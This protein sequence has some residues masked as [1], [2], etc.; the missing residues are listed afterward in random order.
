MMN[1]GRAI[2]I[3]PAVLRMANI[4][5]QGLQTL[6]II[7]VKEESSKKRTEREKLEEELYEKEASYTM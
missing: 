6:L 4:Q 7:N 3:S 2:K 5:E 1:N